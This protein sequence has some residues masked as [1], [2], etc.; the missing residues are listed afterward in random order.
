M[1][2]YKCWLTI[3]SDECFSCLVSTSW[4]KKAVIFTRLKPIAVSLEE[5]CSSHFRA[6]W[7]L[8]ALSL[9]FIVS[10]GLLQWWERQNSYSFAWFCCKQ[11]NLIFNNCCVTFRGCQLPCYQLKAWSQI[12]CRIWLKINKWEFP[13]QFS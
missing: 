4:K 6:M 8:V 5:G 12:T 7:L 13:S 11:C 9:L 1:R 3:N 10:R 2:F